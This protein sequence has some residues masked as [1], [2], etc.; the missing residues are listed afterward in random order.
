VGASQ[1]NLTSPGSTPSTVA[2]MSPEQALGETVDGRTHL[3]S[4]GVVLYGMVT[5]R[6]LFHGS[7]TAA[8]F[9]AIPNKAPTPFGRLN[10]DWPPELE[11]IIGQALGKDRKLR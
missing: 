7:T 6:L 5:G 3:F 9:N 2:Y 8:V 11:R 10:P 1:E 4:F